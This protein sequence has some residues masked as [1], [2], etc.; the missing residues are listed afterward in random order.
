MTTQ[1][2]MQGLHT[3]AVRMLPGFKQ[4]QAQLA[5]ATHVIEYFARYPEYEVS[6]GVY[7]PF[8]R[9]DEELL[10][11]IAQLKSMLNAFS[12]LHEKTGQKR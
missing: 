1:A 7:Q 4:A 11:E 2:E 3:S 12:R 6:P 9:A 10:E 8:E 5:V